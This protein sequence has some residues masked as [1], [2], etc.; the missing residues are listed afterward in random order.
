MPNHPLPAKVSA[1]SDNSNRPS[2]WLLP[3]GLPALRRPSVSNPLLLADLTVLVFG[4]YRRFSDA[5]TQRFQVSAL[6][7]DFARLLLSP[8]RTSAPSATASVRPHSRRQIRLFPSVLRLL[9]TSRTKKGGRRKARWVKGRDMEKGRGPGSWHL[10]LRVGKVKAKKGRSRGRPKKVAR[11]KSS[12]LGEGC[13]RQLRRLAARFW[14][15]AQD[16]RGR[17]RDGLLRLRRGW[18]E[19]RF[20]HYSWRTGF[21]ASSTR[22]R[23][24]P[25]LQGRK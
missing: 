14:A 10:A 19:E 12:Q 15:P 2:L 4:T 22:A 9:P 1:A 24:F 18:S 7:G 17:T 23:H 11:D 8:G 3:Q 13:A 5:R 25:F 20:F 16:G 6:S 21:T